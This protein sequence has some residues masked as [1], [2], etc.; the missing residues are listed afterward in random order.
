MARVAVVTGAARGIGAATV[1]VLASEGWAVMALDL[2]ANDPALPYP[3]GT[4]AELDMV[5]ADA[6]RRAGDHALVTPIVAE[7]PDV[8]RFAR[9]VGGGRKAVGGLDAAV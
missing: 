8:G 9:A 4:K 6:R 7:V 5:V 1:R 3:L 2:C